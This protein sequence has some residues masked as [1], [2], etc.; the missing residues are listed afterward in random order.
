VV[1]SLLLAALALP[2]AQ[3]SAHAQE[4]AGPPLQ[5]TRRVVTVL[6]ADEASQT[7]TLLERVDLWNADDVPFVPS[8]TGSQ[9]PMGLLRFAL[10]RGAFDLSVDDR[11]GAHEVIQVD[12]GFAS[13]LPLPPGATD[14]T[15]GYRVPYAAGAHDL[16]TTVVYPTAALWV[17]VPAS[18]SVQSAELPAEETVEISRHRYRV[19][20]G[21]DLAA[22]QRVGVALAGLPF[23]PRPWWLDETFQRAAALAL[24]VLG[25]LGAWTY[26]RRRGQ[27]PAAPRPPALTRA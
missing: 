2:S 25:V 8:T 24:A 1:L 14:V 17:L 21:Q 11:L 26:A 10:P 20:I 18:L 5:I 7:L 4:A 27:A 9:G 3:R 23:T 13:F 19:R 15:F 6:H 12:R 22:G 16:T